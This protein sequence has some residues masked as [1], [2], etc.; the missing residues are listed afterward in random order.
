M[1]LI[2]LPI[3]LMLCASATNGDEQPSHPLDQFKAPDG[4]S[5]P[6]PTPLP[7]GDVEIGKA[8]VCRQD[9]SVHIPVYVNMEEGII[10][11]VLCLPSGKIH[12]A[13]LLTDADP[14]HISVA[15]KLAGFTS[16]EK[17]FP[18][19]DD[20]LNWKPFSPPKPEDYASS[21]VHIELVWKKDGKEQRSDLSDLLLNAGT[22]TAFPSND[23][24][25][26][27]SYFFRGRYQASMRGD[28]IGVFA[29]RGCLIN[30][31]GPNNDGDNESGWIVNASRAIPSGTPATLIITRVQQPQTTTPPKP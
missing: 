27:N 10:E 16:F 7:N 28:I 13:L 5:I 29:D 22:R 4:K 31:I 1:R 23:W 25:Y 17:L 12:E 15:M 8:R 24:F 20:N 11:Y 26:T 19:Q 30:Y 21:R 2:L 3:L 18:E 9:K 6:K 14:L